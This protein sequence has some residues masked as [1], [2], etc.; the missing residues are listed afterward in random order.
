MAC[1]DVCL[2]RWE[3]Q[4]LCGGNREAQ[5]R[6]SADLHRKPKMHDSYCTAASDLLKRLAPGG[7]LSLWR[8]RLSEPSML[9]SDEL[10][11]RERLPRL[12]RRAGDRERDLHLSGPVKTASCCHTCRHALWRQCTMETLHYENIALCGLEKASRLWCL[13]K[14]LSHASEW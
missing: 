6:S 11:E 9:R 12:L 5:G 1:L 2:L 7:R 8:R 4:N 10:L 13:E 14:S 3:M